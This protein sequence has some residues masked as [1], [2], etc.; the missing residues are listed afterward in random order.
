MEREFSYCVM[1]LGLNR[2]VPGDLWWNIQRSEI[3][4]VSSIKFRISDG[5][6]FKASRIEN[7]GWEVL[8]IQ[9]IIGPLEGNGFGRMGPTTCFTLRRNGAADLLS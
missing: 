3:L 2:R 5:E 8:E 1:D 6:I 4:W 9:D 7:D